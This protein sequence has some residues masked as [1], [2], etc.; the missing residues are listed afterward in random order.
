MSA[1]GGGP[2]NGFGGFRVFTVGRDA[3]SRFRVRPPW[4]VRPNAG[5]F[6][7]AL[8]GILTFI[9]AL[10][11]ALVIIA[12]ALVA[13]VLVLGCGAVWFAFALALWIVGR[14]L[15]VGRV[16]VARNADHGRENV[17]VIPPRVDGGD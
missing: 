11:V 2:G 1:F 4:R 10:P 7:R 8:V 9:L 3:A 6:E 5:P 12:L 16:K 15:G 13:L 17:R 14:L